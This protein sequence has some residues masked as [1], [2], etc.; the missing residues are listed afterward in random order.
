MDLPLIG[1]HCSL[2]SC[3]ELDLLPIR[4]LCDKQYCRKHFLPDDHACPINLTATPQP[5]L[6]K[7]QRCASVNCKK[8]SLE[9]FV[10]SSDTNRVPALCPRCNL[11]Y[12]ASH[13][14]P[15]S[16]S[17]PV[18]LI[19]N[20]AKNEAA[21]ALLTKHFQVA[22]RT[23]SSSA[24]NTAPKKR[25]TDPKKLAQLQK[26]ELMQMRHRAVPGD[27]KDKPDTILIDQRLH[28]KI[29][30]EVDAKG[31]DRVFWFRKTIGVGKALDLLTAQLGKTTPVRPFT[32]SDPTIWT[33]LNRFSRGY[34]YR[35]LPTMETRSQPYETT[36]RLQTRLMMA[37]SW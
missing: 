3:N 7:L 17:C 23:G 26:I 29:K 14:E 37:P 5:A 18:P 33:H 13:R 20:P 9:A 30:D 2:S 28:V 1:A 25:P 16:H 12:C 32:P 31:K 15:S 4:C 34:G 8:P 6:D 35:K 27:P 21:H 19:E 11:A 36:Y 22:G 10:R 24:S